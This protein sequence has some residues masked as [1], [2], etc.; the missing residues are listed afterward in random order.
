MQPK[1]LLLI[2]LGYGGF[3]GLNAQNS[4]IDKHQLCSEIYYPKNSFRSSFFIARP[5]WAFLPFCCITA[6]ASCWRVFGAQS[7]Y[8]FKIPVKGKKFSISTIPR[9]QLAFVA[10]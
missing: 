4:P 3:I 1:Q 7:H 5:F 8:Q 6:E 9:L 2:L 10:L